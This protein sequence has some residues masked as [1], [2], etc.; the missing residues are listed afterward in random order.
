MFLSEKLFKIFNNNIKL[1]IL[2]TYCILTSF[3]V[4][5]NF[6]INS[7]LDD[8]AQ[9]FLSSLFYSQNYVLYNNE[10]NEI[11]YSLCNEILDNTIETKT[12]CYF[13]NFYI[14]YYYRF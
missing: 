5:N 1:I 11:K 6:E 10:Y 9:Y 2:L 14:A 8:K 7:N 13:R 12:G 4:L 3:F